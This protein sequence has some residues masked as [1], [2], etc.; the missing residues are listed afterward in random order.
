MCRFY[1]KVCVMQGA[2]PRYW[3]DSRLD[4]QLKISMCG[5]Y[6]MMGGQEVIS[7]KKVMRDCR[8]DFRMHFLDGQ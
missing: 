4:L 7:E 2:G 1:S 5:C 6:S 3:R 8:L